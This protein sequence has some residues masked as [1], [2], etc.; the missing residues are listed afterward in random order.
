MNGKGD[1]LGEKGYPDTEQV[2]GFPTSTQL[3]QFYIDLVSR[4]LKWCHE[5]GCKLH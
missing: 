3:G 4:M 1:S 2:Q 5:T